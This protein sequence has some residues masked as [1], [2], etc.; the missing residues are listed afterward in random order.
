MAKFNPDQ[1]LL[2]IDGNA[3]LYRAY[4]AFPPLTT[5][6]GEPI[7]AVYGFC[8]I[9]LGAIRTLKPT[10]L[11]VCF[12]LSGPTIRHE[13]YS[14]Y[15]ATRQKMPDEMAGQ[16]PRMY[17]I[18]ETMEFPIYVK[19]SYEADDVIGTLA[20]QAQTSMPVII[21]SGDHDLIQLVNKNIS[22][23]TP[24]NSKKPAI[25]WNPAKVQSEY[26]FSP[27]QMIEYKALRGDP[28]DNIPGVTGIGEV[29]AKILLS[30]FSNIHTIY[31][32]IKNTGGL[33]GIK[34]GILEKLKTNEEMAVL[35]RK[36]A[37]IITDVEVEIEIERCKSE[38]LTPENL[39]SLFNELGFKSL[40]QELPKSHKLLSEAS[41][42]FSIGQTEVQPVMEASN[43]SDN[44]A[45][46]VPILRKTEQYGVKVDI[47]YLK[48]LEKE[49]E[50]EIL[51]VS[52]TVFEMA[53]EEFNL[54]SP[55]QLAE[56]LYTKLA[57][58]TKNISKGKTGFSTDASTLQELSQNFPIATHILKFREL[59]KLQNTYV[60]PLQ[61][62][63][64][65][66]SRVHT[67]YA[68]DTSTGRISSKNPNLQNI[69]VKTDQGRRIR[70]AFIADKGHTLIAADY[71]QIELRVAAHL[72]ADPVMLDVFSKGG[73]LHTETANRMG[74]DRRIAKIINFSILY[75]K[76]AY[77]F[78][79]DMGI[80]VA[81]AKEYIE[82][83]FQTFA[84]LRKYL[85][86]T[87]MAIREKG[88]A[89][90]IFGR[91]K[92]FLDINS[93]NFQRKS[94]AER[95][96][97]N[98]PIQGSA[99]DILK[100]AMLELDEEL[101]KKKVKSKLILTVHDEL[102]IETVAGEEDQVKQILKSTM[103]GTVK[104]LIPLVV[105]LKSG[106]NWGELE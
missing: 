104:L 61:A 43:S 56:I 76:G 18:V 77:G 81:Q 4:F 66:S 20:N 41:D 51:A 11:A 53:G 38:L 68:V 91:K 2:L 63:A 34:P 85:D 103:E 47:D 13:Q 33:D 45:L 23:Y 48:G 16:I 12:D 36:L 55:K 14:E 106:K 32:N 5:P 1:K 49:F 46:L 40:I 59:S 31:E 6:T 42:I 69:P 3:L 9:L 88:Y 99:A 73:D 28:S 44:D 64:D 90:T 35:S 89:E 22:L 92:E 101:T 87:L 100:K 60:L 15:K 93:T 97:I 7:G 95:E 65:S 71:S 37:T 98:F 57:I 62:L 8:R 102:I 29:T 82:Q 86:A 54:G 70:S 24:G 25:L 74:V 96:A 94:A 50:G 30:K 27:E 80:P 58:P 10:H 84:G 75:G 52:K 78:S 105:S 83:Y 67:T 17:Q 19:K 21:L 26:G 39:I 79:Q 72:S